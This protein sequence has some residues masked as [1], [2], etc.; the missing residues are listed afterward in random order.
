MVDWMVID[1][2]VYSSR[3]L[4]NFN[5]QWLSAQANAQVLIQ[6]TS[7]YVLFNQYNQDNGVLLLSVAR[8]AL[9]DYCIL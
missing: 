4:D 9:Y 6:K 1:Q 7:L 3:P 5:S 2:V 8:H